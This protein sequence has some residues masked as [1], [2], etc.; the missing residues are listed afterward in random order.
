M[1]LLM[2][3]TKSPGSIMRHHITDKIRRQSRCRFPP[4]TSATR[5]ASEKS[6]AYMG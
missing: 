2:S 4:V 1:P 3:V 5:P 6:E